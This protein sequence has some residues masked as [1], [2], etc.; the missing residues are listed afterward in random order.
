M[1]LATV[2]LT[3][4]DA[5]IDALAASHDRLDRL[6]TTPLTAPTLLP[7][8]PVAQV[9]SH[10]GSGAEIG[11][12]ILG[13]ALDGAT[14]TVDRDTM[15]GIWDRWNAM[16]PDEQARGRREH[17]ARHL[18][19]LEALTPEQ[20]RT[21]TVPYFVGPLS[22]AE[23]AGY[24][25]SEHAMH[26]WDIAVALDPAAR[27]DPAAAAVL[28]ARLD[29]IAGRFHAADLRAR[30]APADITLQPTDGAPAASLVIRPDTVTL[31]PGDHGTA[32]VSGPVD[33]LVRLAY[34]R[35]DPARRVDDRL[36]ITAGPSLA[37]LTAL[38]PGY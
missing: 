19:L 24:R 37:D 35:L 8:W 10:L 5:M 29:L 31:I 27:L 9:L 23:Y 3:D 14:D 28:W 17:D 34:G 6:D 7:G 25:L 2:D 21:L 26:T 1:T 20:R 4:P 11:V 38:F 18:A 16:T 33:A 12:A 32:Q 15:T 36:D 30:L 22:V 13:R